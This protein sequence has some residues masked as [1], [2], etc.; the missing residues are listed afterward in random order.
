MAAELNAI[1]S[2][3]EPTPLLTTSSMARLRWAGWPLDKALIGPV[4]MQHTRLAGQGSARGT[5][6]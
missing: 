3:H 6:V 5:Q 2:S 4:R 1:A